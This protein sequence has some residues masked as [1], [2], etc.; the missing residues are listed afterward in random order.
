MSNTQ[1]QRAV[2]DLKAAGLNPMLAYSQGGA[3]TPSGGAASASGGGASTASAG[4][5]SVSG[6][7][8]PGASGP[9]ASLQN[10]LGGLGSTASTIADVDVKT[11]Q[12]GL[13]DAQTQEVMSKVPMNQN[14]ASR[15]K[16]ETDYL[17]R[18]MDDRVD[19][20]RSDRAFAANHYVRESFAAD[21]EQ[22]KTQLIKQQIT[23]TEAQTQYTRILSKLNLT[24]NQLKELELPHARNQANYE[25]SPMG[26]T[27]PFLEGAGNAIGSVTGSAF[28]LKRLGGLFK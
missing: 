13:I 2:G 17:V 15:T 22:V 26:S 23:Q 20:A 16:A 25:S 11:A 8:G 28:G 4:S 21:V 12:K 19:T 7:S 27:M 14:S 24:N 3:G 5:P 9:V 10:I 1:Y 6:A 18:S